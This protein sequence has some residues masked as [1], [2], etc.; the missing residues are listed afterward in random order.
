MDFYALCARY[1][2]V[3]RVQAK[4]KVLRAYLRCGAAAEMVV[5]AGVLETPAPGWDRCAQ[6]QPD[7]MSFIPT[8]A[9]FEMLAHWG[10]HLGD[11]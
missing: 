9:R 5:E 2:G 3:G 10:V 8:D 4:L 7:V 11:N 6:M 1:W